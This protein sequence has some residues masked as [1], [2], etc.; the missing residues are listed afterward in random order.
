MIFTGVDAGDVPNLRLTCKSLGEVGLEYLL[1]EVELL[2]T[3]KSFD[4]LRQISEHPA[5][6]R[7]VKSLVYRVDSVY[8]HVDHVD[9]S[10]LLHSRYV[11]RLTWA[12]HAR[13]GDAHP[14]PYASDREVRAWR[15]TQK[16]KLPPIPTQRQQNKMWR[17]YQA[18]WHEQQSLR[19]NGFGRAQIDAIV[20]R[21]TGL[22]S[23]VLSNFSGVCQEDLEAYPRS[24][25]LLK[26]NEGIN[27]NILGDSGHSHACG[28]PQLL[29]LI[30]AIDCNGIGMESLYF[31]LVSW[32]LFQCEEATDLLIRTVQLLK[33][34]NM[35][36]MVNG[37]EGCEC[38]EL[39]EQGK[40]QAFLRSLLKLE[41]F[42]VSFRY[43]YMK[44]LPMPMVNLGS[45]IATTRWNSLREVSLGSLRT[46]Q[47]ELVD[48]FERHVETLR[49]MKLGR[50]DMREGSWPGVFRAM[51]S[52]LNLREFQ[53]K[54]WLRHERYSWTYNFAF[55]NRFE[56]QA[57]VLRCD[58]THL[59]D[60]VRL[61]E[62][63]G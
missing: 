35:R 14:P 11:Q 36:I 31:G 40:P 9:W 1:P 42:D 55:E 22:R 15:R 29:S 27:A 61:C 39:F 45:L 33:A 60:P 52:T 5:L 8:E 63:I 6:S 47:H 51:R 18:L 48:F 62:P 37:G 17:N 32:R 13:Y 16:K 46:N 53:I 58:G 25:A 24:R 57:Y 21:L 56:V 54:D 7:H 49:V 10:S 50:I 43:M 19:D 30:Q 59:W 23:I 28:V 34:L 38:A 41:V 26:M 4:R 2:F 44:G 12:D 3:S 20:A